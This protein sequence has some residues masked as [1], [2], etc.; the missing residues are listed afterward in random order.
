[1]TRLLASI[2]PAGEYVPAPVLSP[3]NSGSG[4][5]LKDREPLRALEALLAHPSPRLAALREAIPIARAVV[6]KA[7]AKGWITDGAAG[8]HCG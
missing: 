2:R 3:W 7:R 1:M 5:G 4:I 6:G 8:L